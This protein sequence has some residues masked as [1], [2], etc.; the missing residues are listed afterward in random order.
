MGDS[1][2]AVVTAFL[3]GFAVGLAV[4]LLVLRRQ[5]PGSVILDRD[6]Q[7]RVV[8]IHYVPGPQGSH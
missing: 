2:S 6:Q 4:G 7:G 3:A 5:Q 8:A 1:T